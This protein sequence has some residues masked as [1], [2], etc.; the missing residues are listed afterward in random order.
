[1]TW[2]CD[3]C[4]SQKRLCEECTIT[5]C[6]SCKN[7][8]HLIFN[9]SVIAFATEE[10]KSIVCNNGHVIF[11]PEETTTFG[12]SQFTDFKVEP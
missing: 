7:M 4:F 9:S 12:V 6:I 5:D 1:M 8:K 10:N 3:E 11:K 2:D